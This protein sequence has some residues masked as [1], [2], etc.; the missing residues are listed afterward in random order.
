MATAPELDSQ[1]TLDIQAVVHPDRH[2]LVLGGELDIASAPDLQYVVVRLCADSARK[3]VLDLSKLEFMDSTGLEAIL[4]SQSVCKD[5]GVG[6]VL[7]PAH[8]AVKRMLEITGM[9]DAL[10]FARV[11]V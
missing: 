3:I 5:H 7:T 1:S 8:G 6:F 9:I 4:A 2:T 10:P 11:A